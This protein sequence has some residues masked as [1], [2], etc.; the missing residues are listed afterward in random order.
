M[1]EDIRKGGKS[2]VIEEIVGKFYGEV[3]LCVGF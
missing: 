1:Y 3:K 2:S